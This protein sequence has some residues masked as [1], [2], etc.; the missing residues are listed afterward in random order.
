VDLVRCHEFPYIEGE[1]VVEVCHDHSSYKVWPVDRAKLGWKWKFSDNIVRCI[2]HPNGTK[3]EVECQRYT[4][5][6]PIKSTAV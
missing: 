5:V 3:L 4:L 6:V 2:W 1:Y